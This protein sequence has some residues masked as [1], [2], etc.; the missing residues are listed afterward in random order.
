M[1][2]DAQQQLF[3]ATKA[4]L[5]AQGFRVK[6]NM[7]WRHAD[8]L[9]QSCSYQGS[10]FGHAVYVHLA[11]QLEHLEAVLPYSQAEV[12]VRLENVLPDIARDLDEALESNDPAL[13]LGLCECAL[14]PWLTGVMEQTKTRPGLA[15]WLVT[16]RSPI[17]TRRGHEILDG[18]LQWAE[19]LLDL[20][21]SLK[22]H[23]LKCLI[24]EDTLIVQ[25]GSVAV[26]VYGDRRG[27]VEVMGFEHAGTV[28]DRD[29]SKRV[30]S[31]D[32]VSY[33]SLPNRSYRAL[34]LEDRIDSV[35]KTREAIKE[36]LTALG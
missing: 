24:D 4:H 1:G 25:E 20:K 7:F 34:F 17:I 23:G 19:F 9:I 2:N 14:S 33:A 35:R 16:L 32:Y 36:M 5:A 29:V 18:F 6:R 26:A 27:G 10:Q 15:G 11:F 13:A 12:Q 3:T 28:A 30:C 31:G 22:H 21:Q 8:S